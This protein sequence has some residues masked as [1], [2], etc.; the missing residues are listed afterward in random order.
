MASKEMLKKMLDKPIYMAPN[1]Y[2]HFY[3]GGKLRADFLGE[4]DP[5][6]D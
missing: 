1:S 2:L 6:D 4:P 3:N 5:K